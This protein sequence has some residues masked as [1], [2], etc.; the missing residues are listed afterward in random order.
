MLGLH[1]RG[2]YNRV[3]DVHDCRLQSQLSNRIVGA[4][5]GCASTGKLPVYNLKTHE[6]ILR[7]LVVREGRN[8]GEV[9]VNLVVSEYLDE[10]VE[11]LVRCVLERVP[12]ITTLVVT[13]HSGK[14]QAVIG[15]RRFVLK[16]TSRISEVCGGIEL[17]SSSLRADRSAGRRFGRR[18]CPRPS[19]AEQEESAFTWRNGRTG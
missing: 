6:G 11:N 17:G 13:L 14:A 18:Y 16:G 4:V 1:H 10:G 15:E 5:R 3:F 7:F 8:S 19:T 12:E 9:M 2:R